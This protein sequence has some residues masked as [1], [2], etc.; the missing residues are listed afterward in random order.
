MKKIKYFLWRNLYHKDLR[1]LAVHGARSIVWKGDGIARSV[2][3]RPVAL[4]PCPSGTP[5]IF[6][7]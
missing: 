6:G 2:S 1:R 4:Y 3:A 7:V 5:Q